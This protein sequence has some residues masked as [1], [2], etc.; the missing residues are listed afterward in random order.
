LGGLLLATVGGGLFLSAGWVPLGGWTALTGF[1]AAL[2]AEGYASATKP[3][4]AWYE[5]RA[6]AESVK[7][8]AWR[9]VVRGESFDGPDGEA[10]DR[11]FVNRVGEVLSD[12][13]DV[14]LVDAST[15]EQ[16]T[17]KMREIRS[18]PFDIRRAT[19]REGRVE[20]QRS[21]YAK[22]ASKNRRIGHSWGLLVVAAEGL[23]V[24]GGVAI[25]TVGLAVDIVGVF[26]AVAATVTAWTQAK[27]YKTL[28]TAY[29]LTAQELAGVKSELDALTDESKWARF[30][31]EAEEAISREHTL[32]RASRGLKIAR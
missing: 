29:G 26:A 9:Y 31:G 28:G 16:I 10:L 17:R 21:W 3:D 4:R 13:K 30:V 6:A 18:S 1:L 25:I 12:L 23:G 32:W 22:N 20:N 2:L 14:D 24:L 15:S 19:Y 27:Q 5:G 8:L 11:E 7:T